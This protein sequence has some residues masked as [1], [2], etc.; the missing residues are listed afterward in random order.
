MEK[1]IQTIVS[2]VVKGLS[3]KGIQIILDKKQKSNECSC[4]V[5]EINPCCKTSELSRKYLIS[6]KAEANDCMAL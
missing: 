6:I 4:K 3:Q 2:E 5:E 1:L